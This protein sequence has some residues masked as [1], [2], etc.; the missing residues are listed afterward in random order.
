MITTCEIKDQNGLWVPVG[1]H[2]ALAR[3]L[4]KRGVVMRCPECHG[5]VKACRD[6]KTGTKVHFEHLKPN[7]GCSL[8]L[9]FIGKK[10]LHPDPMG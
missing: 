9:R 8:A 10:S 7:P 2:E 3:K 5:Q 6:Y 4:G 1:I